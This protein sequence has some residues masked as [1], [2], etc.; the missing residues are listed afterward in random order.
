MGRY[1]E[2]ELIKKLKNDE[3]EAYEIV[4]DTY[5]NRL[6]KACYL[7]LKDERESEDVVQETFL[8]V[9]KNI[10]SFKG[11]SSL[12]TW[13]YSI[14]MNLCKDMLGKRTNRLSFN[15]AIEI[16]S[17]SLEDIALDNIDK[18]LL[19]EKLFELP[20]IYKEVLILFYFEDLSIK[21]I[22]RILEEKEGT[23]KSKLS[24][25][26]NILKKS[27]LKGGDFDEK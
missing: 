18:I 4:L 21:E 17:G 27:L 8:K 10:Q 14:A 5:G 16:E 3:E 9:F 7:I 15:D 12:Y 1:T 24:R 2:K 19:K 26:R 23:I 6:I 20:F 25:G 22:S 13:L 11:K